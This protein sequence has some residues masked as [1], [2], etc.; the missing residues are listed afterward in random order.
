MLDWQRGYLGRQCGMS[1]RTSRCEVIP[2]DYSRL[3]T[4]SDT[5]LSILVTESCFG[6]RSAH[7]AMNASCPRLLWLE[8]ISLGKRSSI[9]A[10]YSGIGVM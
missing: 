3:S 8:S 2:G 1:G 5:R 7:E 4:S 6:P 10:S 9:S